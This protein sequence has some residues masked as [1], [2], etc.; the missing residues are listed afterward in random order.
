MPDIAHEPAHLALAGAVADGPWAAALA[1]A[2]VLRFEIG[3]PGHHDALLR[4]IAQRAG[5][6]RTHP[7]A[8]VDAVAAFF[9]GSALRPVLSRLRPEQHPAFRARY[10]AA[11]VEALRVDERG[12]VLL[13]MPRLFVVATR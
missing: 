12:V 9:E 7:L 1:A 4:P 11:L 13:A 3:A 2:E 8:G 10:R 5:V 6:W